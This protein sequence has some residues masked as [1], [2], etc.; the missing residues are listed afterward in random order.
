MRFTRLDVAVDETPHIDEP[1]DALVSRL[2]QAKAAQ[3]WAAV[4]GAV[5]RPVLGADTVVECDGRIMGKPQ[6]RQDAR[7]MIAQLSGRVHRVFSAVA[8]EWPSPGPGPGFSGVRLS[9][10]E[11][12]FRELSD[13]EQRAY[14]D[15]DE[16][17]DKA[18]IA[19]LS[20]SQLIFFSAVAPMMIDMFRAVPVRARE[21]LAL[22]LMRTAVLIPVLAAITAL[23][24]W[25]GL[26]TE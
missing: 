14:C 1:A 6:D 17:L 25:A 10:T 7:A 11:V 20:I 16:P 8:I 24:G 22:F 18:G 19:V 15:T 23:L 5:P 2:A 3:G 13:R 12:R 9:T 21:L 26:L 4:A